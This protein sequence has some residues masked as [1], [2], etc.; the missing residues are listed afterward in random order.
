MSEIKEAID[1]AIAKCGGEEKIEADAKEV[2]KHLEDVEASVVVMLKVAGIILRK[3][4][5]RSPGNSAG[6]TLALFLHMTG[7]AEEEDIEVEDDGGTVH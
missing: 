6:V 2:L 5:D 4:M 7:I 3:C 1:R